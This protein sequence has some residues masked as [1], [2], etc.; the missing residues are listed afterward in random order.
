VIKHF[1]K[2]SEDFNLSD[3]GDAIAASGRFVEAVLKLL[4]DH[5]GKVVPDGKDFK[6]GA[7]MS[8]LERIPAA[9]AADTVRTTIPRAC[10]FIYEVASNRG[11]RHDSGDIDP[12]HMDGAAVFALC[13][14]ILAEL[15]RYSQRGV[16]DLREATNLVSDLTQ[17][18]A[19][20][21]EVIDGRV[22]FHVKGVS[23]RRAALLVLWHAHPGRV[24]KKQLQRD[25]VRHGSSE[26]NARTAIS[27]LK[28]FVDE[29]ANGDLKLLAPGLVEAEA[30]I[31]D[32]P[33][34]AK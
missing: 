32:K 6:A 29:D 17:K 12:N 22:Y 14:W 18:R 19:P 28:R 34:V 30:M 26:A 4:W 13:G 24:N 31:L 11:A 15:V 1:E 9:D 21:V 8:D 20:L 16:V 33:T 5:V 2:L 7:V 25:V 23:A 10:R 27:R 3:W